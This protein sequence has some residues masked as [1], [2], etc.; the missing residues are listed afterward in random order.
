MGWVGGG[1]PEYEHHHS[2]GCRPAQDQGGRIRQPAGTATSAD[3]RPQ[4][5]RAFNEESH[6]QLSRGPLVV[7]PGT[8]VMSLVSYM[9]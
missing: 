2:I 1:F 8:R 6:Q 4:Q 9:F 7:Q 3:I 5:L